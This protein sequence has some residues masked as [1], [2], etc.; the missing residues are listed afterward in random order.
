MKAKCQG[1][2]E[3]VKSAKEKLCYDPSHKAEQLQD[4]TEIIKRME[5]EHGIS[6]NIEREKY[7]DYLDKYTDLQKEYQQMELNHQALQQE[8]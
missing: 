5:Y 7:Q 2:E 8:C 3:K 4:Q 1:L 6:L